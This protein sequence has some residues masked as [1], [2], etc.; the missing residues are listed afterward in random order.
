M[1]KMLRWG[2]VLRLGVSNPV[3]LGMVYPRG[4]RTASPPCTTATAT[5]STSA[6]TAN[7]CMCLQEQKHSMWIP[8]SMRPARVHVCVQMCS[9]TC[10]AITQPQDKRGFSF[11]CFVCFLSFVSTAHTANT[12]DT[13]RQALTPAPQLLA[14]PNDAA[15]DAGTSI[16]CDWRDG[17]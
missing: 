12:I 3:M 11:L 15:R 2:L 8:A 14:K 5:T 7:E 4:C 16:A 1:M 6:D 17:E 10:T 9:R 13:A